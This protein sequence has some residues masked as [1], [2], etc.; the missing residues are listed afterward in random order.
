[1]DPLAVARQQYVRRQLLARRA[2]L[3]T[4]KAWARIDPAAIRGTWAAVAGPQVL[5]IVTGA[6]L[7][8]A[9]A[10]DANVNAALAAQGVESAPVA[11]VVAGAF[12]GVASDGRDLASLLE[13]SN[14]HALR[15]IRQG[16]TAKQGLEIGG[17]WLE[18]AVGQQVIDADRVAREVATATRPQV[19][20]YYR[21]LNLPSCARCI[22]LAGK[23]YRWSAGF[24]RH[25]RCDC[26]QI[27][28]NKGALDDAIVSPE[29]VFAR[30]GHAEQNRIFTPA[31][32]ESIRSGADIGQVVN[33]RRGMYTAGGHRL[34]TVNARKFGGARLMP[35]QIW[36]E[37][38]GK[39]DEALRLLRRF[40]YIR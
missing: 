17:R 23:W 13:L 12:A 10:A 2:V 37:A 19:D 26:S 40:G 1:M 14:L 31:G 18:M 16:Q 29:A 25:P 15:A 39:R 33:A 30:M 21:V 8:A 20:G 35:E 28:A 3:A 34:T 9:S 32:A 11:L 5:A 22:L 4:R 6:Q 27:E 38:H 36:R 7:E 24:K